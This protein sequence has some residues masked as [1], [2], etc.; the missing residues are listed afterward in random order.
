MN[1]AIHTAGRVHSQM[2]STFTRPAVWKLTAFGCTHGRP[3]D[4]DT[5]RHQTYC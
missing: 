1:D 4:G 2:Q 3:A 5:W